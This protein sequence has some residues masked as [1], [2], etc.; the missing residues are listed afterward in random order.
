M[1][2]TN[3]ES[4][5]N[6]KFHKNFLPQSYQQGQRLDHDDT[7]SLYPEQVE[8]VLQTVCNWVFISHNNIQVK[9]RHFLIWGI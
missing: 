8:V 9:G 2:S 3:M 5:S 6:I 7:I 4:T 1:K